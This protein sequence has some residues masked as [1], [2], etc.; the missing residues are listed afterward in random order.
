MGNENYIVMKIIK[1]FV[2]VKIYFIQKNVQKRKSF[3]P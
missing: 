2:H 3:N 1:G